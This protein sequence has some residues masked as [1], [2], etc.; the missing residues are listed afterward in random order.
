MNKYSGKIFLIGT[1]KV[2][3]PKKPIWSQRFATKSNSPHPEMIDAIT[4]TK[5]MNNAN[6]RFIV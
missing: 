2:L 6:M 1:E 4:I 3:Y 5:R